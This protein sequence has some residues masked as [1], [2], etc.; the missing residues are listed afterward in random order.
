MFCNETNISNFCI[1]KNVDEYCHCTQIN[2]VELGDL[3]EII[4]V[5]P[6]PIDFTHPFHVSIYLFKLLNLYKL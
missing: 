3:V 1:N 5:D 4:F 6:G 2:E